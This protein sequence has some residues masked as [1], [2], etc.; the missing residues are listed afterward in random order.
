[1]GKKER[2]TN[3]I[4]CLKQF[5]KSKQYLNNIGRSNVSIDHAKCRISRTC[6]RDC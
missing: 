2:K 6:M 4:S 1:M 5:R 3:I